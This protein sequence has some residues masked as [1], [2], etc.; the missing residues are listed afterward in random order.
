M[1]VLTRAAGAHRIMDQM[2]CLKGGHADGTLSCRSLE[3]YAIKSEAALS[4]AAAVDSR[5]IEVSENSYHISFELSEDNVRLGDTD[6]HDGLLSK[7]I[8]NRDEKAMTWTCGKGGLSVGS[9]G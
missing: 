3:V 2:K 8:G 9:A 5:F 1:L 6:Y 7:G 4:S